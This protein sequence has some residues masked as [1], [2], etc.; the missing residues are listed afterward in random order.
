MGETR[1]R[2][3]QSIHKGV[4]EPNRIV[5]GDIIVERGLQPSRLF[6]YE[7]NPGTRK[8]GVHHSYGHMAFLDGVT[9]SSGVVG[10]LVEQ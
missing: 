2:Q 8:T 9:S 6:P 1:R 3:I 10:C 4:D 7:L 5:G